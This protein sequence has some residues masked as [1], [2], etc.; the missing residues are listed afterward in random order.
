M[1]TLQQV[2][3][4][5]TNTRATVDVDPAVLFLQIGTPECDERNAFFLQ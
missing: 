2:S 5:L 1:A 4:C 3:R